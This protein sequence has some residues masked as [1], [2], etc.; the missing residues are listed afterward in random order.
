MASVIREIAAAA[1]SRRGAP[2]SNVIEDI[3]NGTCSYILQTLKQGKAV[4]LPNF[5]TFTYHIETMFVGT[6]GNVSKKIPLFKFHPSFASLCNVRVKNALSDT[7][8]VPLLPLSF[9]YVGSVAG[10]GK[11]VASLGFNHFIQAL[12]EELHKGRSMSLDCGAAT[13]IFSGGSGVVTVKFKDS[14]GGEE[15]TRPA[16]ATSSMGSAT[17]KM[18][19]ADSRRSGSAGRGGVATSGMAASARGVAKDSYIR[20]SGRG[21]MGSGSGRG[22]VQGQGQGQMSN[23]DELPRAGYAD[24]E[25]NITGSGFTVSKIS[26]SAKPEP[27]PSSPADAKVPTGVVASSIPSS[28]ERT[29]PAP[30]EMSSTERWIA[31][32]TRTLP[33]QASEGYTPSSPSAASP[34]ASS[35]AQAKLPPTVCAVCHRRS[36]HLPY[37]N[38]CSMCH[39]RRLQ[40]EEKKARERSLLE[41]E[42]AYLQYVRE[43]DERERQLNEE[44]DRAV[45][46]RKMEADRMNQAVIAEKTRR[47][48]EVTMLV[49]SAPE[50][51]LQIGMVAMGDVFAD[52]RKEEE[53]EE[54]SGAKEEKRM[55]YRG[56]LKRQMNEK[57]E[58]RRR[59]R[60]EELDI[61]A[62]ERE[63]ERQRIEQERIREKMEKQRKDEEKR[64][65]LEKQMR[66][67]RD[68][69]PATF[70]YSP[71]GDV[72]TQGESAEEIAE[73]KER[74]RAVMQHALERQIRE[75]GEEQRAMRQREQELG[76][77]AAAEERE[78][79][80]LEAEREIGKMKEKEELYRNALET[81]MATKAMET[82]QMRE[83]ERQ[84]EEGMEDVFTKGEGSKE[85]MLRRKREKERENA[86]VLS[87]MERERKLREE[88]EREKEKE[89]ARLVEEMDRA[90]MEKERKQE[91]Q[92]KQ[93]TAKTKEE[94]LKQISERRSALRREREQN[95]VVIHATSLQLSDEI[96]DDCE[97][98]KYRR[99]PLTKQQR[100]AM[101]GW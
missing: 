17:A 78:R 81:Q 32:K 49:T 23:Q 4:S 25:D 67:R 98:P 65:A 54:A 80:A 9:V 64:N 95:K 46:E 66:E 44:G 70:G 1:S 51:A 90:E 2:N 73:K 92:R 36:K 84:E 53:M 47:R 48:Q 18:S 85:E 7:P 20:N 5:G 72:F 10:V 56:A 93:W 30:S 59:E 16:G 29:Q 79:L 86:M 39:T 87:R 13:L 88:E 38:L 91:L 63:L 31:A 68:I 45:K 11:D 55:N 52:R 3:W 50:A 21:G 37:P 22:R 97:E 34:F 74:Q 43:K 15:R 24:A 71:E 58:M 19:A 12:I 101:G 60:E 14:I 57:D 99:K 94:Q 83:R 82:R 96:E 100:L 89:R 42:A 40:I 28:S 75:K 69:M 8:N 41:E 6:T 62:K 26:P 61:G 27:H 35:D 77:K 33:K 76:I